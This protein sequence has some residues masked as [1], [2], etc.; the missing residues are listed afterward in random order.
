MKKRACFF[1]L[2]TWMFLQSSVQAQSGPDATGPG[3]HYEIPAS[4][5]ASRPSHPRIPAEPSRSPHPQRFACGVGITLE[6]CRQ[7]M[8]VLRK[9][10][11]NYRASDLGE[12]TWV[13]VR[14]ENW[15]L[16]LLAR[17]LN[18]GIP[19]LTALD[20]R[21]TFF[22]EALVSGPSGRVSEL[23]D[24]WHA[25]RDSLLDLAVR[26][27]LGHA[28]C[29]EQNEQRADH[30]ARLLEQKKPAACEGKT[31]AKQKSGSYTSPN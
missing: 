7:E 8:V 13:L 6:E 2:V 4:L 22:E 20:A 29:T 24:I 21:T 16:I 1:C 25:G 26:H 30:V 3:G 23:M 15:K 5:L 11:A 9:T 31:N 27:E 28:L 14:S 12:W 18:P 10:L 17:G 19:A